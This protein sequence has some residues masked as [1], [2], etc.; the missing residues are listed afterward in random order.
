M[1]LKIPNLSKED[2]YSIIDK[3]AKNHQRKT[4]NYYTTE[5]MYGIVWEIALEKISDFDLKKSKNLTDVKKSLEHWLNCIIANKLTNLY[6]DEY[7]VRR[8]L[9]SGKTTNAI[10]PLSLYDVEVNLEDTDIMTF[11]NDKDLW[12]KICYQ[13]DEMDLEIIETLM[14]GESIASYYR[15]KLFKKIRKILNG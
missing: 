8:G 2:V 3:V 4:F 5:D 13:L 14:S 12:N 6:R 1:N 7:L 15:L 10:D 11:I 9:R